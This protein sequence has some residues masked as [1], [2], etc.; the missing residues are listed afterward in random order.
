MTDKPDFIN[1]KYSSFKQQEEYKPVGVNMFFSKTKK[2][3]DKKKFVP[4]GEWAEGSDEEI[5]IEQPQKPKNFE[6]LDKLQAEKPLGEEQK[7]NSKFTFI[8]KSKKQTPVNQPDKLLSFQEITCEDYNFERKLI[9]DIIQPVGAT[10]KPQDSLLK[11]FGEKAA[12]F[13]PNIIYSIVFHILKD[14]QMNWISKLR[15][16]YCVD[17]LLKQNKYFVFLK[18]NKDIIDSID[19]EEFNKISKSAFNNMNKLIN[20]IN[21]NLKKDFKTENEELF[22]LK[23]LENIKEQSNKNFFEKMENLK[24]KNNTNDNTQIN[25]FAENNSIKKND[26]F[27]NTDLLNEKKKDNLNLVDDFDILNF[28]EEKTKKIEDNFGFDFIQKSPEKIKEHKKDKNEDLLFFEQ[29]VKKV[30][31]PA[32]NDPFDFLSL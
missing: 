7:K 10:K 11:E 2:D 20:K 1:L 19:V 8:N 26:D 5:K 15:C 13:E 22:D 9:K 21:K 24:K 27:L 12:N 31:V 3:D 23:K 14:N 6:F 29:N 18:N 30:E 4:G 32:K 28:K 17:F 16:L 25:F